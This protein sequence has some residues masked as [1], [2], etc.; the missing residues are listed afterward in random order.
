MIVKPKHQV[1]CSV[2]FMSIGMW[3]RLWRITLNSY[4]GI[5]P[6]FLFELRDNLVWIWWGLYE[7]HLKSLVAVK[8]HK[9]E[10]ASCWPGNKTHM[11]ST[12][13]V[14]RWNWVPT[15]KN[16]SQADEVLIK[17]CLDKRRRGRRRR[18]WRRD[19]IKPFFFPLLILTHLLSAV[20]NAL[21]KKSTKLK[22]IQGKKIDYITYT[23]PQLLEKNHLKK[24]TKI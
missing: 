13:G 1:F 15:I 16:M 14:C 2:S 23:K 24:N 11:P 7:G 22:K 9:M 12:F 6:H 4:S 18:R 19:G 5:L 8:A 10:N 21:K 17:P 20:I 3:I